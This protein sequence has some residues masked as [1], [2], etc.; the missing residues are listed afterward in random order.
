MTSSISMKL[1]HE[2]GAPCFNKRTERAEWS[3]RKHKMHTQLLWPSLL[4]WLSLSQIFHPCFHLESPKPQTTKA[5]LS[6]LMQHGPLMLEPQLHSQHVCCCSVWWFCRA[7]SLLTQNKFR[8]LDKIC[9]ENKQHLQR[10]NKVEWLH[11]QGSVCVYQHR[12]VPPITPH[13]VES[14]RKPQSTFWCLQ[15]WHLTV[16]RHTVEAVADVLA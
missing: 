12:S 15:V 6:L 1:N 2:K 8:Y 13:T 4:S 16:G 3:Q 14:L 7:V 5:K 11:A 9:L 10:A